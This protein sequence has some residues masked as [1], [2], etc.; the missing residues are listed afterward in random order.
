MRGDGGG[1]G[2]GGIGDGVH[3]VSTSRP[4]CAGVGPASGSPSPFFTVPQDGPCIDPAWL[5]THAGPS[6]PIMAPPAHASLASSEL[7]SAVTPRTETDA[8]SSDLASP[9]PTRRESSPRGRDGFACKDCPKMF[10]TA[11]KLQTH[12]RNH[13]KAYQCPDC[14]KMLA[15]RQDRDRCVVKHRRAKMPCPMCGKLLSARPDNLK[16]HRDRHCKMR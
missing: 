15:T 7:S 5:S 9:A 10:K 6:E 13:N 1:E 14:R 4:S 16:R 2:G 12:K 8:G 11:R 3:H